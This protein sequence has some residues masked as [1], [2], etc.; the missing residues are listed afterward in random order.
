MAVH[1]PDTNTFSLIDVVAAV[2]DHAGEITDTLDDCFNHA[3]QSFFDPEYNNSEYA[4]ANS[5]KRFRNYGPFAACLIDSVSYIRQYSVSGQDTAPF[6][7]FMKSDGTRMFVVGDTGNTI[8]EYSLST[9]WSLASVSHIQTKALASGGYRGIHFKSDGTKMFL[10]NQATRNVEE[11][12]L[13]T[14]WDINTLS[15]VD[16]YDVT[17]GVTIPYGVSFNDTGTEMYISGT[18][19]GASYGAFAKYTLSV[20]FDLSSTITLINTYT[21]TSDNVV[22]GDMIINSTRTKLWVVISI[23]YVWQYDLSIAGD[24]SSIAYTCAYRHGIDY[25]F[26]IFINSAVSKMYLTNTVTNVVSE[27]TIS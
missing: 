25:T 23:A 13:S 11:H 17:S 22:F 27:F 19:S 18:T 5:M 16:D 3:K 6:G 10:I 8:E 7:I 4:P 26:G 24:L 14:A 9:A 12:T 20:G 15:K 1:V 21:E 2:E